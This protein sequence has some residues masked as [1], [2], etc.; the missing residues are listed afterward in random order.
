MSASTRCHANDVEHLGLFFIPRAQMAGLEFVRV[1][2][3]GEGGQGGVR[4]GG[5]QR[6]AMERHH[7][8]RG[9]RAIRVMASGGAQA[10][11]SRSS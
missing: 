5:L 1:F 6:R 9:A 4:H 10:F 8:R 2:K 7:A 3:F 11:L